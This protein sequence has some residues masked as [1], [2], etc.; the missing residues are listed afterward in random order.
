MQIGFVA[1]LEFGFCV[2]MRGEAMIDCITACVAI[3]ARYLLAA[4]HLNRKCEHTTQFRA[5]SHTR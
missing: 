5:T 2:C 1:A 4:R 3:S